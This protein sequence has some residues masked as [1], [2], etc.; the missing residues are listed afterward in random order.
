MPPNRFRRWFPGNDSLSRFAS[1]S[2]D[3]SALFFPHR[4][5]IGDQNDRDTRGPSSSVT[6]GTWS[7]V[8]AGSFQHSTSNQN[9]QFQPPSYLA[10]LA[11]RRQLRCC[12]PSSRACA[13]A[14]T[15]PRRRPPRAPP[16]TR[17]R[18]PHW[19]WRTWFFFL[20]GE[21]W[22]PELTM[23]KKKKTRPLTET[24]PFFSLFFRSLARSLAFFFVFTFWKGEPPS[25]DPPVT[26]K[27]NGFSLPDDVPRHVP[28]GG[29]RLGCANERSR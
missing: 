17:P 10:P 23:K 3:S 2:S 14:C 13:R 16:W 1:S 29:S 18:G 11:L 24:L 27:Q 26:P 12:Y 20:G 22:C 8:N 4:R 5:R 9:R 15:R 28:E 25:L 6:Q 7:E 19:R 21:L